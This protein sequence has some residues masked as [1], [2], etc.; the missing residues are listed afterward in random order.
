M[1]ERIIVTPM[2][3]SSSIPTPCIN[4]LTKNDPHNVTNKKI[5]DKNLKKSCKP[6]VSSFQEHM[7]QRKDLESFCKSGRFFE[8][9]SL[10]A[11][12]F[13]DNLENVRMLYKVFR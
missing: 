2:I 5:T 8:T 7:F 9:S 13:Q 1:K 6:F 3:P 12:E 11:E 10:L 4:G